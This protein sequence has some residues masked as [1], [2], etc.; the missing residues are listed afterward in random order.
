MINQHPEV[1]MT[2]ILFVAFEII[3]WDQI[4]KQDG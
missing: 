1:I 3:F 2:E 4:L